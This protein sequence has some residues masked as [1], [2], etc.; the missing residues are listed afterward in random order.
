MGKDYGKTGR[1]GEN[2][3]SLFKME[4]KDGIV[5]LDSRYCN[6][7]NTFWEGRFL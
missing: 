5:K 2:K 7:Y 4:K 1:I 6:K 3:V